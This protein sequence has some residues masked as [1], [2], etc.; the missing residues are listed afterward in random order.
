MQAGVA[1]RGGVGAGRAACVFFSGRRAMPHP[2]VVGRR[3]W[4]PPGAATTPSHTLTQP[5]APGPAVWWWW[6]NGCRPHSSSRGRP[7]LRRTRG[8]QKRSGAAPLVTPPPP[9]PPHPTHTHV[10]PP[11]PPHPH[12]QRLGLCRRRHPLP[13]RHPV[14]HVCRSRRPALHP[15]VRPLLLAPPRHRARHRGHGRP[16]H[17]AGGRRHPGGGGEGHRLWAV[18]AVWRDRGGRLLACQRCAGDAV[19]RGE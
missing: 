14:G 7:R 3:F 6:W 13:P 4:R 16:R 9:P 8:K 2:V 1:R 5:C 12:R 15:V 11:S 18:Q 17:G 10:P 19:W